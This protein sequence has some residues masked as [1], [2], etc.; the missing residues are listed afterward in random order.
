MKKLQLTESQYESIQNY[1][2]NA[3]TYLTDEDD[4]NLNEL[5]HIFKVY[6]RWED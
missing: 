4:P 3:L 5:V 6:E 2:E 1:I